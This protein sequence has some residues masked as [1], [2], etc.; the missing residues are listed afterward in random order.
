MTKIL[1]CSDDGVPSGYGRIA[2]EVNTRLVRR[3][4]EVVAASYRYD[5][6]LPAQYEG[7]ALPY[8][9]AALNPK[10]HDPHGVQDIMPLIG[11]V[12]P[13][14]VLVIQDA[15]FAFSLRYAPVDWSR[16]G[17]MVITPVD[18]API[19]TP[20]IDMLKHT[21]GVMSIS[22]F[23]VDQMG[24]QG[25]SAKLCRPAADVN[26]FYPLPEDKKQAVRAALGIDKDAFVLGTVAMN[27]GR[28]CITHMMQAFFEFAQDKPTARYLL[29]MDKASPAGWDLPILCKQMGWDESKLIWK[30]DCD[31]A[32]VGMNERYNIMNAHAVVSHRE[33]FGLPLVEAQAAGVV[34]IALDYCSGPEVCADGR[35]VL[36]KPLHY[37]SVSTWGNALDYHPDISDLIERLRWLHDNPAERE[38]IA[39]RG[40]EWARAQS[41]DQAT[42]NVAAMIE[43]IMTK[44][45]AIPAANTPMHA[46]PVTQLAPSVDGIK[47]VEQAV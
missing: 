15:P 31:R 23:G 29:N 9:V 4:Y 16:Y 8:W 7:A 46:P 14:I 27:Q 41:W 42:D 21:D 3:G 30:E 45:R 47:L 6:K 32:N 39:R 12:N 34:S 11:A 25:V 13:D 18:G 20:W 10:P 33:G 19:Y 24:R 36:I 40:M 35:G 22:Q 37:T 44:R 17:F 26:K 2:M 1:V 38:T 5:G 43:N 28:K